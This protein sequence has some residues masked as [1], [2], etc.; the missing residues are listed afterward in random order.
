[1]YKT[2]AGAV[3]MAL[4]LGG[5]VQ[6][7]VLSSQSR[8]KLFASQTRVLDTRASQQ[9]NSSVR[10]QPPSVN[11]PTKWGNGNGQAYDGRYTGPYLAMAR[12]AARRHGVPED[13]FL[14]LVQQELG[15]NPKARSH[16][17]ALGLAQLMPETA[18]QLRVDPLD[19]YQNLDGGAR[20]L[21]QQYR[22][23]GNWRLALAAYN[24]GPGAV[25]KHGG[26]PPFRETQN[27]VRVI[28]GG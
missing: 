22:T 14:K 21:M 20:Y 23:F 12:D 4:G 26:V 24:A 10:L 11:T 28:W 13:L 1:M 2:I 25:Q 19:P 7:D 5:G 27:Y 18:R 9:Y 8:V 3:I 15:F 17:G 6:A 16:K